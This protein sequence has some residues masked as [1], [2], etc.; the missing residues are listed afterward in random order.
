M[1]SMTFAD[2]TLCKMLRKAVG[3]KNPSE[4]E[5]WEQAL[6]A[7][8]EDERGDWVDRSYIEPIVK[9]TMES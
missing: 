7:C 5:I 8:K 1:K 2:S 9:A 6:M 3:K 4:Y